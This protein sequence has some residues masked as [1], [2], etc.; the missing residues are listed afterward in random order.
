[1]NE[2]KRERKK[3]KVEKN[4]RSERYDDEKKKRSVPIKMSLNIKF[5]SNS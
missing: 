4:P 5:G 3:M 1:M 2:A